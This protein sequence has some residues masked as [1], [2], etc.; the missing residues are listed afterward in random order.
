MILGLG[1]V[2]AGV[3]NQ[4]FDRFLTRGGAQDYHQFW[5]AQA[6]VASSA[7]VLVWFAFPREVEPPG[8]EHPENQV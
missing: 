3:F 4:Y 5:I 8:H 6:I 2:A 7:T 1:P